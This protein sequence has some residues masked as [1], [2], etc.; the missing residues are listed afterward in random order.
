LSLINANK[1][2]RENNIE[3]LQNLLEMVT[4]ADV[5]GIDD[6]DPCVSTLLKLSQRM[7]EY[8]L[9]T[10]D[11]LKQSLLQFQNENAML[12]QLNTELESQN[13]GH[14]EYIRKLKIDNRKRRKIIEDLQKRIDLGANA[15]Y[16]CPYCDKNFINATFLQAHLARKHPDKVAYV[17][18]ALAHAQKMVNDVNSNLEKRNMKFQSSKKF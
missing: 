13:S 7:T 2:I 18:D 1:I 11:T 9:S 12:K 5:D 6:I 8:T 10:Q 17:G 4:F 3:E 15:Y 14:L 16:S